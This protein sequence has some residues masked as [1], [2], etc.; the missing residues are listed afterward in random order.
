M[1]RRH[2]FHLGIQISS[3]PEKCRRKLRREM[4]DMVDQG[5]PL[6]KSNKRSL[7]PECIQE[8]NKR[9]CSDAAHA[10]AETLDEDVD[11][12]QRAAAMKQ[13]SASKLWGSGKISEAVAEMWRAEII[14]ARLSVCLRHRAIRQSSI[15]S[16]YRDRS[17][18]RT[19]TDKR[20]RFDLNV[21]VLG[22]ADADIDRL[23]I[24]VSP[25]SRVE[26]LLIRAASR[27]MPVDFEAYYC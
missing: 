1:T 14:N 5:L 25:A 20:V 23:P 6:G 16:L 24:H 2:T 12:L 27:N 26:R 11:Y 4:A 9:Q 22:C 8:S 13:A 7:P 3:H 15:K 19:N 17:N 21:V 10:T 18:R